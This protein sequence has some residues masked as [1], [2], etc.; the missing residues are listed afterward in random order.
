MALA[1][2]TINKF[3]PLVTVIVITYNSE[4]YV[5]ETLESIKFQTYLN[6]E[7]IISDD[8]STDNT[9]EICQVWIDNNKE[10]FVQAELITTSVN[11][12]IPANCNRGLYKSKGS[13]IKF[14]AGDDIL[15]KTCIDSFVNYSKKAGPAV[16]CIFSKL[17]LFADEFVNENLGEIIPKVDNHVFYSQKS[18]AKQQY[19][20][21]LLFDRFIPGPTSFYKK[22]LLIELG[23]FME[24]YKLLEDYPMY[25][26]TTE[27]GV[28]IH[29]L[30][31]I[32]VFYRKHPNS[33][34]SQDLDSKVISRVGFYL[35]DFFK[36]YVY[37]RANFLGKINIIWL[38]MFQKI[39]LILGNKGTVAKK[40]IYLGKMTKPGNIIKIPNLFRKLIFPD[41]YKS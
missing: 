19:K 6:I 1:N 35:T 25:L 5:I 12:G 13:W 14:I 17:Q 15:I 34:L 22:S 30:D 40:I 4:Q 23:G 41:Y 24:K 18:T 37:P 8:A 21:L 39:V 7:L 3:N 36:E 29:F 38:L 28:K 16:K 10:R 32:T 26:R 31:K 2:D 9:L 33:A 11:T 27:S 20:L